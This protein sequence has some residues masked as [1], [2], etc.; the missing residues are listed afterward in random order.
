MKE[1]EFE[2][3]LT[4]IPGVIGRNISKEEQDIFALPGR[5]GGMAFPKPD[6]MSDLKYGA[7]VKIT[8]PGLPLPG[9]VLDFFC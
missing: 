6:E 9:K 1:L 5:L 3:H 4:L 7:S 2:I 8:Q